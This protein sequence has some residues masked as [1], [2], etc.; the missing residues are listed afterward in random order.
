M[1]GIGD[2][3]DEMIKIEAMWLYEA[4]EDHSG[5]VYSYLDKHTGEIIRISEMFET[6]EEKLE[7]YEKIES[8]PDRWVQIDPMSSRDGFRIMERFV[9]GLPEG[10]DRRTLERALSYKKPFSNFRQAM[11]EMPALR[12]QW[13]KFHDTELRKAAEEWLKAEGIEA[14]LI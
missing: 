8:E 12:D 11:Q 9:A 14:E 5:M 4:L 1:P 6:E 3:E 7:T 13:F 2:Q 10:E